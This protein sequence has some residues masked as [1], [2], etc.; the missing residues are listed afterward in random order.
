MKLLQEMM[1][2]E[3]VSTIV[4]NASG[5]KDL[6]IEGIFMQTN[7]K[8]KNGRVYPKSMM[9]EKVDNY[10]KEFVKTNRAMGELEHPPTPQINL[11]RV[12]HLITDLRFE[13]DNIY[14]KAKILDTPCGNIARGLIEGGVILGVSSRGVGSLQNRSGV[15]EVQNDFVLNTVDLVANPSAHESF[16]A[17]LHEGAEWVCNN[18]IWTPQMVE[19]AQ[20]QIDTKYTQEVALRIFQK[21]MSSLRA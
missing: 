7:Q 16:V 9:E 2:S 17:G 20:K 5:K 8:N 12:S 11:D 18:G 10:L 4:E 6:F 1:T 15:N 19:E 14:G 3:V 13:G 21:F